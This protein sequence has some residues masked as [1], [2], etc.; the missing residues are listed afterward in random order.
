M[1]FFLASSHLGCALLACKVLA[2]L[3]GVELGPRDD[4]CELV[5]VVQVATF[6]EVGLE[7]DINGLPLPVV[8]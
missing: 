3:F 7:E 5:V 4:R 8:L 1:G 6:G 2:S